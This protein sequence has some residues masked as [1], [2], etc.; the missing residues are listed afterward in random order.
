MKE[1]Y[2]A[3]SNS[4]S[5]KM[6]DR[7]A[8]TVESHFSAVNVFELLTQR[9]RRE[10]GWMRQ[11]FLSSVEAIHHAAR[12]QSSASAA[13]QRR[14]WIE[15]CDRSALDW[16]ARHRPTGGPLYSPSPDCIMHAAVQSILADVLPLITTIFL[17]HPRP[18]P[19]TITKLQ[20]T[21]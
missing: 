1:R 13:V 18:S 19:T 14:S 10:D 9:G 5:Q 8:E 11:S 21:H 4:I 3:H 6:N 12:P 7:V 20:T 17:R 15:I 2:N 16:A